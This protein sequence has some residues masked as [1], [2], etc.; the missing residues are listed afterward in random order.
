MKRQH[1]FSSN[2]GRYGKRV[3][4][5]CLL[6]MTATINAQEIGL[7]FNTKV[8]P[9]EPGAGAGGALFIRGQDIGTILQTNC[10]L[11]SDG[12]AAIAELKEVAIAKFQLWDTNADLSVTQLELSTALKNLFPIPPGGVHAVRM[13]NGV[14]VEAT[15]EELPTPDKQISKHLFTEADANQDGL[16]TLQELSDFF[17]KS[18]AGWDGDNNGLLDAAELNKAFFTL[19]RPDLP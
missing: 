7:V 17:D 16:I 5:L 10:D 8:G 18:F 12:G 6:T 2:I 11:N 1:Q 4:A 15:P 9:G 14:A 19:S 13:I 3:I